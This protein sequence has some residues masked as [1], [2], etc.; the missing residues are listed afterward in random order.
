MSQTQR[1]TVHRAGTFPIGAIVTR[2]GT[3]RHRVV[4]TNDIGD[5]IE[6]VCIVAAESGWCSVGETECNLASRYRRARLED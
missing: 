4:G 2:D 3:D 6:V 5:L 1:V